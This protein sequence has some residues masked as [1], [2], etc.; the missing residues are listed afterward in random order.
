MAEKISTFLMFQNGRANEAL[1]AYVAL[2]PGSRIEDIQ[3]FDESGPGKP[4]SVLSAKATVNGMPIRA[5]DSPVPHA[6]DFTPSISLFVDCTDET[7]VDR[8][9][10]ELSRD[11]AV[12][13]ELGAYPFAAKFAWVADRFGV[14]WQ[15]S[16]TE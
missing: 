3:Y 11:G 6:V 10:A 13:M 15:L 14:S 5:F 16:L 9:Y 12:M 4:G 2:F 1:E 8:L 7:E